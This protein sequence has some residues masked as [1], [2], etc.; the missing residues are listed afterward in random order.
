[1]D[2]IEHEKFVLETFNNV[3]ILKLI[4][5][6]KVLGKNEILVIFKGGYEVITEI[7]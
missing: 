2:M 7:E 1:M 6:I 5:C 3:L 4:E